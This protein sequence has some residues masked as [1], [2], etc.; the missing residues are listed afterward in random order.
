MGHESA[1]LTRRH[2]LLLSGAIGAALAMPRLAT[3][4]FADDA[5][6]AA[7]FVHQTADRLVAVVNGPGSLAEKREKMQQIINATV[8]VDGIARFCLGQFWNRATPEQQK[9]YTALFHTVLLNNITGNL[10]EYRGV[11][12]EMG[13]SQRRGEGSVVS[14]TVTRPNNAPAKVDW[15]ISTDSGSPRIVDVVAEGTSLRLTQRS[16]YASYI[17]HNGNNVQALIDAMKQ[18]VGQ[19]S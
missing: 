12:F 2:F 7:A 19:N 10:G 3:V 16:D 14:T 5:D 17:T 18:Q 4:A 9:T 13:R 11:S 1:M 6:A 15:I 8:D